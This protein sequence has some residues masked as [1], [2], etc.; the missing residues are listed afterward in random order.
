MPKWPQT[1]SR[2]AGSQNWRHDWINREFLQREEDMPQAKVFASGL[3]FI[4]RNANEDGWFLQ[5]E[6]FDPHEPFYTQQSY[7]DLYS[8]DYH[9]KNLD[10]PD[11]GKNRYGKDAT[12]H[13][14][15]EYAAL[16]SMCDHYLGKV[17]DLMDSLD[18]WKDTMLIVNTD[19]GFMLGEKE[20]MGKN[21]QPFYNELVHLP[22]FIHVPGVSVDGTRCKALAQS[23]DIVPTIAEYFKID[24][25]RFMDGKSLYPALISDAQIRE[26][27]LFGIFG[28]SVNITDGRYVYMHAPIAP[29]NR[30]LYEYTLMPMHMNA[31]FQVKE[32]THLSL[33]NEFSFTQLSQVMKIPASSHFNAY[34]YGTMLFDLASD[35][36]Q[37]HCIRN[38]SIELR[39]LEVM[40]GMMH[41]NEAPLEQYERLGI[42]AEGPLDA[43]IIDTFYQ[44]APVELPFVGN[45]EPD[46]K[47]ALEMYY[48]NLDERAGAAFCEKVRVASKAY[49]ITL[50]CL[51]ALIAQDV[52]PSMA[53][54][55]INSLRNYL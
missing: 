23:V 12:K 29:Q 22:F 38:D 52:P 28:G 19:H 42:P 10:W 34:W 30:P 24:P 43:G 48:C 7:K 41:Q 25:P 32:L 4:S 16:L 26:Y 5:I 44:K 31:P 37:E 20:W 27:A 21:V 49:P 17:L 14:R 46:A 35:P 47:K 3:D 33:T 40:R 36:L 1:L 50:D 45:L 2:R 51:L 39:L 6:A 53:P 18:L 11:Y 55:L 9:G 8:D 15:R 54:L 13:V